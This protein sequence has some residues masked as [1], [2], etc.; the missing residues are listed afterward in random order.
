MICS[1]CGEDMEQTQVP[2]VYRNQVLYITLWVCP[3]GY[4]EEE[5]P[6]YD[7]MKGGKD[8]DK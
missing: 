6:D 3:C 1:K 5:E 4:I 7:S 2:Q 8:Y